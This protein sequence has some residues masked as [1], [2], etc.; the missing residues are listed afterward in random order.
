MEIIPAIDIKNGRCVRLLQGD[1]THEIVYDE[2]PLA[3]ARRWV[4]QGATRLHV[5]DL[6]GA[7]AGQPVHIDV[8]SAIIRAVAVPVQVGGGLRSEH[9]IERMLK[10]G[11]ARV[12][13]GTVAVSRPQLIARMATRHGDALAVGVDARAG[14]VAT[15]GWEASAGIR[16]SD[17]VDHM[18][19]LGVQHVIYTDIARDGTL[20][21]P[22]YAAIAALV[23][24]GGPAIIA[25]GGVA[26]TLQLEQLARIGCVGAIVGRALYTGAVRLPEALRIIQDTQA[27]LLGEEHLRAREV[28]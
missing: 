19:R 9:E 27:A 15:H 25:S 10:I 17:L 23:R 20:S 8:I 14:V 21:E 2:S 28:P 11:A 3:V 16:A 6:D 22:N 7:R 18:A 13:V 1:F 12:V 4:E 5:V 24:P 26:S